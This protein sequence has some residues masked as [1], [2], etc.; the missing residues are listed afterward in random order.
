MVGVQ[1]DLSEQGCR[2]VLYFAT[3]ADV[4]NYKGFPDN[5]A[6][7]HARIQAGVWILEDHLHFA[8]HVPQVFPL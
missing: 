8:A 1:A 6:D 7:G 5:A 2:A 3:V 4:V